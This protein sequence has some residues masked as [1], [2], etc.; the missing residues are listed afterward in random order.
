MGVQRFVLGASG[1]AA[2]AAAGLVDVQQNM[3]LLGYV[4]SVGQAETPGSTAGLCL[5]HLE[6]CSTALSS[7]RVQLSVKSTQGC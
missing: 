1:E 2:W 6:G 7:C 3:S 5:Q 4:V